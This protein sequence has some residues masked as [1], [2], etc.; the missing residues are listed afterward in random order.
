MFNDKRGKR[1]YL[2]DSKT[3]EMTNEIRRFFKTRVKIRWLRNGSNQEIESLIYEESGLLAK[4]LRNEK[5]DWVPR[6]VSLA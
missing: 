5:A 2:N 6:V 4:F 1:V 3:D